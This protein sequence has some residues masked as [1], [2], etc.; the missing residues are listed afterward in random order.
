MMPKLSLLALLVGLGACG[1][2]P[3]P[4]PMSSPTGG[5]KSSGGS[6]STGGITLGTGGAASGGTLSTGG[7]ATGGMPSSG[8]STGGVQRTGGNPGTGGAPAT[9]GINGP[10][11]SPDASPV[12]KDASAPMPD[13]PML[14]TLPSDVAIATPTDTA[15]STCPAG[16]PTPTAGNK[17]GT[18]THGGRSRGY[19]LHVPSGLPT[20]KPLPVVF[21]FHGAG[22]DGS[23]QQ[24]MSG[25]AALGDRE[26]FLTVFPNGV[27]GYW[28]VDDTC[29]GT[30]GKN[31]IDD[32]GFVKAI[33][34][35]L[36]TEICLDGKRV[37][38]SGFSNG[39]GFTHRLGCDAADVFAGIAPMSTDLR[40]QP[41]KPARP[42]TMLETRGM[43]DSLEPYDGGLVGPAGGQYVDVGA[44]QSLK[45]WADLNKCT[46]SP[47]ARDTYCEGYATCGDGVE[48]QL[49][50]LPKVDHSPY[51]NALNF[52]VAANAWKIFQRHPMK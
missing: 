51:N 39:G 5:A 25:W 1:A 49:C 20:G 31:K 27:D 29:C 52:N 9:G 36:R 38:A 35:K 15:P 37:F 17:T 47:T 6:L 8:G 23:Q 11:D 33:V 28:N 40:T 19:T 4:N 46:D 30:A 50:S 18:L 43:A 10:V 3:T 45:L 34:E 16:L 7:S 44:K 22:G 14:D 12:I 42:I 48:T 24:G 2:N 21:D 26:G 13:A 32:V 41:C